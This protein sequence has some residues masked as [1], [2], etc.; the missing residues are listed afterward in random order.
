MRLPTRFSKPML[1]ILA[2]GLLTAI[3][4]I[5]RFAQPASLGPGIRLLGQSG[6]AVTVNNTQNSE[7]VGPILGPPVSPG[8][9][10]GDVRDLPQIRTENPV[11][12]PEPKAPWELE[13]EAGGPKDF[14]DRAAQKSHAPA[15]MPAPSQ[16]FAGLDFNTWGGGWPP[17]TNGDVGPSHYIQT[18]N[19][20]IGIYNKTGT[21]LAAFSF[22]TFF[23]GAGITGTPCDANNNGDPVVLYDPI[24]GRWIITDFAWS[25][26]QDGPYYECIAVSKTAD[27]VSGGWWMYALDAGAV[28][29]NDWL[30]DYPKLGIW[31]DGIYMGMNMFDCLNASCSSANYTGARVWALNRD[32]LI[33]GAA[34]RTVMFDLGT[35]YFSVFPANLRGALPPANTPAFF[36]AIPPFASSS[37]LNLWEFDVDWV[38]PANSTFTG[39]TALSVTTF[40]SPFGTVPQPSPGTPLDDLSGRLMAQLQYRN[41][42]GTE[43]IWMN[44]TVSSGGVLGIR[45]YEIRNPNN[46]P[47]VFQQSTY[48]PDTTYRWMGSL[49]VDQQGNMALGFSASSS[50][51]NPGIRYA[52]RL[53]GD[54]ANTLGQGEATLIAGTGVQSGVDRWG[55]Y[56]AM[57]VDPVDDCTFWYTTEY[58]AANG[59]N[60]QTRIGSFKFPGCTSSPTPTPTTTS[61]RTL[62]PTITQTPTITRTPTAGPSPTPTNTAT[63]PTL[64]RN[65]LPVI[66]K[67]FVPTTTP[68][69]TQ[70]TCTIAVQD[71]SFENFNGTDN[72]NWG[73]FSTNFGTP[74]CTTG[75]CGTGNGTAGPRS[76]SVWVWFGGTASNE[77][78]YVNQ[79]VFF[80]T[81]S[82]TTL[83]FYFWIGTSGGGGADDYFQAQVD[84]TPLF[85]A[86]ATQAGSYPSYTPITLNLNAY[87]NNTSHTLTFY[88]STSGQAVN[89]N[90]DDVS[91]AC[92][93]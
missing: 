58:Y 35:S 2:V 89:F 60:W 73:E 75:I 17:D 34:L 59:T 88:S 52:G 14:V 53:V 16:N 57:T 37:T 83:Q 93:P 69:A 22:D 32:D 31:S 27:P 5:P 39:P 40:S 18:V 77:T 10:D 19:T 85:T 11:L 84:G 29:G 74:L 25:N 90:L 15:V 48:Q 33:S 28:T 65:Y 80:P 6:A 4:V 46:A 24:S 72:P 3:Y 42:G 62:T 61:T 44:H 64:V 67:D 92:T 36:G 86:N 47:T 81:A 55:D 54:T 30:D 56:S 71:G 26:T 70:G 79:S 91:L 82:T 12:R 76:G 45:W 68:T 23:G 63:P 1:V 41:I 9:F 21:Q 49:A 78:G 51:V 8:S 38:T 66:R 43:S 50:S 20:A 7:V 87:G 13:N